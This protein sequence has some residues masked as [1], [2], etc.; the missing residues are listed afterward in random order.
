MIKGVAQGPVNGGYDA[1][2]NQKIAAVPGAP[3]IS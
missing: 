2:A 1:E 3:S